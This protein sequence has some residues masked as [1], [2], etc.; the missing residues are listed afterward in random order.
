MGCIERVGQACDAVVLQRALPASHSLS[1]VQ[2][3][4]K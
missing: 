4:D 3:M 2:A 1:D